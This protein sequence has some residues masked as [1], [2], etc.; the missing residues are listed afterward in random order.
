MPH[1]RGQHSKQGS[2]LSRLSAEQDGCWLRRVVPP[3]VA[4]V[5]RCAR[6]AL[7]AIFPWIGAIPGQAAEPQAVLAQK[8]AIRKLSF[9]PPS[10]MTRADLYLSNPAPNPRAVLLLCPGFNGNGEEL[11]RQPA[12]QSFARANRL[13]L[14]AISFASP[15]EDISYRGYYL[16]AQGSGDVLLRG[17]R[18]GFGADLPVL[19]YGFSGGAHFTASLVNWKPGRVLAWCAYSAAWWEEPQKHPEASP[20]GI[21]ACGDAD[22]GRYGASLNF[23]A[24]GRALGRPWTW[25]SLGGVGHARHAPLDQFVGAY[26]AAVLAGGK[27]VPAPGLPDAGGT[28]DPAAGG[29]YD[30]D[31]KLALSPAQAAAQPV[32]ASWLPNHS[33]SLLWAHLHQP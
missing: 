31:T 23:F 22:A 30:V 11:V 21:V 2:I 5:G 24:K 32:L 20:P 29:W 33:L 13:G 9:A 28:F 15:A 18:S 8:T 3:A 16:A 4:G 26:F 1:D 7:F 14:C 25:V 19:A 12:W 10:E 27:N 17:I 6:V